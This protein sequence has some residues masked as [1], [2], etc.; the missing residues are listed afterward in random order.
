[1][2]SVASPAGP[3]HLGMDTSKKTIVVATL[4]PGEEI[5]VMERIV[6]EEA[7]VRRF[8]GGFGDPSA[9]RCLLR[10]RAGRL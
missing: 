8:I 5:P 4:W 7:A 1:M 10:G 9:L 6:N 3:I 2:T